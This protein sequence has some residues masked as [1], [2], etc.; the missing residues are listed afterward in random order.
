MRLLIKAVTGAVCRK[1]MAEVVQSSLLKELG[2]NHRL[3]K[4]I[5]HVYLLNQCQVPAILVEAGFLSNP[6]EENL[7]QSSSYQTKLAKAIAGGISDFV[8][9]EAERIP[10]DG[11]AE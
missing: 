6:Q 5:D 4:S 8:S 2:N 10:P 3:A 1:E 9:G 7:L 11:S